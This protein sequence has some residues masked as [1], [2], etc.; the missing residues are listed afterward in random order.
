LFATV[1]VLSAAMN[2]VLI[3]VVEYELRLL[4][5][6]KVP[7]NVR[8]MRRHQRSWS[9][10]RKSVSIRVETARTRPVYL[11]RGGLGLGVRE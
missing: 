3:K 2:S 7:V 5:R 1:D 9:P 4:F 6:Y 10:V 11:P 8:M